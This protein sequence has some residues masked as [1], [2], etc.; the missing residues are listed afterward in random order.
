VTIKEMERMITQRVNDTR[1]I[2]GINFEANGA[3]PD[4]DGLI[5]H[6]VDGDHCIGNGEGTYDYIKSEF[7]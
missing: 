7:S 2:G 3:F 5:R 1:A 6:I 4:K